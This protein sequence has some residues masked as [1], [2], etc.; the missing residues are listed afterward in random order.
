MGGQLAVKMDFGN[1]ACGDCM[2]M[3]LAQNRLQWRTMVLAAHTHTHT[4]THAHIPPPPHTHT[5]MAGE[6]SIFA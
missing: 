3:Q 4:H 2:W 1:T 5:N 6:R